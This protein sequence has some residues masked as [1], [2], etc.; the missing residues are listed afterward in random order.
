MLVIILFGYNILMKFTDL[1]EHP[2]THMDILKIHVDDGTPISELVDLDDDAICLRFEPLLSGW[3]NS[4]NYDSLDLPFKKCFFESVGEH[5]L[6]NVE[7]PNFGVLF[8]FAVYIIEHSPRNYEICVM[9]FDRVN[10]KSS[11]VYLTGLDYSKMRGPLDCMLDRLQRSKKQCFELKKTTTTNYGKKV[12]VSIKSVN[13]VI[14]IGNCTIKHTAGISRT[15]TPSKYSFNV[16][17]HWRVIQ[18]DT[19]GKDREGSRTVKGM[20]WVSECSKG[21]GPLIRKTY[22]VKT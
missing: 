11:P 18:P 9:G 19:I 13:K 21:N 16:R 6:F 1:A 10:D 2:I 8:V 14:Y 5:V 15:Y 12:D 4:L 22:V 7:V 20:T 17:G 3:D